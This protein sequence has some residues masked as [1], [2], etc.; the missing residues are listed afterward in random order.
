MNQ[1]F[2]ISE[3]QWWAFGRLLDRIAGST[4]HPTD[5]QFNMAGCLIFSLPRWQIATRAQFRELNQLTRRSPWFLE[6][7]VEL[8]ARKILPELDGERIG[9]LH[10]IPQ[11]QNFH[12][13][14]I[15]RWKR[16]I[17]DSD[18]KNL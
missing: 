1:P 10:G 8:I 9:A 7:A 4:L 18:Y 13:Q 16:Q 14:R 6:T 3:H 15:F 2:E 5:I 17:L 11:Q 12:F